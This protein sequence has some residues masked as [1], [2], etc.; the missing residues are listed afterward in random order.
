MDSVGFVAVLQAAVINEAAESSSKVEE[1]NNDET[2]RVSK[3]VIRT[4]EN[5]INIKPI[6]RKNVDSQV[7][8]VDMVAVDQEDTEE[9]LEEVQA[10]T[11]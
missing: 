1:D 5:T 10:D 8:E 4:I 7:E 6:I 3:N 9:E 2:T 11:V